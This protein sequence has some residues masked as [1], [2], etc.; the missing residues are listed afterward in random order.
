MK[1]CVNGSIYRISVGWSTASSSRSSVYRSKRRSYSGAS[2]SARPQTISSTRST[3]T[4]YATRLASKGKGPTTQPRREWSITSGALPNDDS[5]L[6]RCMQI[7]MERGQ[8][9][10]E[11]HGCPFVT[12][13]PENISSRGNTTT[14][15][16]R[17]SEPICGEESGVCKGSGKG[18]EWRG[19]GNGRGLGLLHVVIGL[20]HIP[21]SSTTPILCNFCDQTR[22]DSTKKKFKLEHRARGR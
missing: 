19:C 21:P 6:C 9:D 5:L 7:I 2:L 15:R 1:S 18:G 13:A 10:M 17:G 14:L 20:G 11:C 12:F 22:N 16:A 4:I 8:K 3:S